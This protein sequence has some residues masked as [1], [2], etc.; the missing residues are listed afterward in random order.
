MVSAMFSAS[1]ATHSASSAPKNHIDP[2]LAMLL[3]N[4]KQR[5]LMKVKILLGSWLI[6]KVVLNANALSKKTKAV[7]T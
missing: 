7:T 1:A 2:A 5:I 3:V 6:P 4:G